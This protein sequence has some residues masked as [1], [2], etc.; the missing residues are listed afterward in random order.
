MHMPIRIVLELTA[1]MDCL[2]KKLRAF[3]HYREQLCAELVAQA[4]ASDAS[5]RAMKSVPPA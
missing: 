5:T 1:A 3:S 2:D 4:S